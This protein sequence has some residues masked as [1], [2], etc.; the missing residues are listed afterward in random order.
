MSIPDISKRGKNLANRISN[1]KKEFR[2]ICFDLVN[3]IYPYPYYSKDNSFW[4]DPK[5]INEQ[6]KVKISSSDVSYRFDINF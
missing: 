6:Y 3:Y 4:H 2:G 1:F 5:K